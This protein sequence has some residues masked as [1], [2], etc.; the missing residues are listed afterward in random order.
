[1]SCVSRVHEE[2]SWNFSPIDKEALLQMHL[3]FD[4]LKVDLHFSFPNSLCSISPFW[5][6]LEAARLFLS[7][8]SPQVY[9]PPSTFSGNAMPSGSHRKSVSGV[10][11]VGHQLPG[12]LSIC[13]PSAGQKGPPPWC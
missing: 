4:S 3:C 8:M 1:M 10:L 13:L 9:W 11:P 6:P 5:A 2:E 7:T 12:P